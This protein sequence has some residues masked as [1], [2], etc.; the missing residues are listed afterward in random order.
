MIRTLLH[1]HTDYSH[2]SDASLSDI[3]SAVKREGIDCVSITDHDDI[4]GAL[5]LQRGGEIRVIVGEEISTAEGHL[6]GLFLHEHIPPGLPASATARLI[7]DQGGV[8]LAPHPFSILCDSSLGR[9]C[10]SI[11]PQL[12]AVEIFNAQ[13][14]LPWQDWRAARFAERHG[15]TGYVGGDSHLRDWPLAPC[16]QIMPNFSDAASFLAA[17]RQAT[18]VCRR[19]PPGYLVR[20]ALGILS[21]KL[22]GRRPAG[23]GANQLGDASP[24]S[25]TDSGQAGLAGRARS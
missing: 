11:A 5:A 25:R 6:I 21:S 3:V 13:N 17:L 14:P 8:V 10:E 22:T 7:H 23:F 19:H 9:A 18:F 20:S 12:D 1:V 16:Y 15:L 4:R 2:D 24:D